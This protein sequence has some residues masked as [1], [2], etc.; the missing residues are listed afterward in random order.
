MRVEGSTVVC[1]DFEMKG[2][3]LND[4]GRRKHSDMHGSLKW[5]K[6]VS[7]SQGHGLV[8][9]QDQVYQREVRNME[10]CDIDTTSDILLCMQ[11]TRKIITDKIKKQNHNGN[12]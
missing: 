4:G 2:H 5:R 8:A 10:E 3:V 12:L 7:L 11:L 6:T 1:M 9:L